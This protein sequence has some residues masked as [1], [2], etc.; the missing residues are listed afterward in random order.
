MVIG[1]LH[2]SNSVIGT[3]DGIGVKEFGFGSGVTIGNFTSA[4]NVEEEI[5]VR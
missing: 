1:T 4:N 3:G 2:V 5:H